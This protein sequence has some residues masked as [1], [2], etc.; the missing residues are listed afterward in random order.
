MRKKAVFFDIDGTL[1][2]FRM[3]I[4]DSTKEAVRKLKENGHYAFICTGRTMASIFDREL[5]S[6]GFD[7]LV[8]GCGTY[9]VNEG[10]LLLNY[11]IP[12]EKLKE[13]L[14]IMETFR[15]TP[16]LEGENYLYYCREDYVVKHQDAYMINM[17]HLIPERLRELDG[18]RIDELH[19][20]KFCVLCEDP[21]LAKEGLSLLSRDFDIM[22][23][24]EDRKE[25]APKGYNKGTGMERMCSRIGVERFDTYAF[26]DSENDL[27]MLKYAGVGIAMGN[28]VMAAKEAA[29]YVTRPIN[30]HGIY[31]GL[32]EFG[33]I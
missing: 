7:G 20:N 16:V 23:L 3:G 11:E 9:I 17:E 10:R 5:L 25:F 12:E 2:D 31:A 26:G 1:Y 24:S 32:K 13:V 22:H 28:G 29:D 4:C 21:V 30:E 27:D 14:D 6:M 18:L 15:M 8:A 19:V 33:L